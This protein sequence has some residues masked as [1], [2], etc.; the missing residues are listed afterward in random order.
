MI[1]IEQ[2]VSQKRRGMAMAVV[3]A[4]RAFLRAK[5]LFS[6]EQFGE[7]DGKETLYRPI[8]G[9]MS[10]CEIHSQ[11]TIAGTSSKTPNYRQFDQC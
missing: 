6:G 10:A 8:P 1:S 5:L 3:E 9:V 7:G 4:I 11:E 2:S